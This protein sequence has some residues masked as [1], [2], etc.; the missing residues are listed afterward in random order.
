MCRY[1]WRVIQHSGV[2]PL[3]GQS[4]DR[5]AAKAG[6]KVDPEGIC[7]WRSKLTNAFLPEA[8]LTKN[9]KTSRVDG[10]SFGGFQT[11]VMALYD[12]GFDCRMSLSV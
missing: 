8:I 4:P 1:L 6:D 3:I 2:H 11:F 9:L 10:M 12:E 5:I 7:S